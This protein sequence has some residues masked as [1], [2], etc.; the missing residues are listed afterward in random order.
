MFQKLLFTEDT[1]LEQ[2]EF[3]FILRGFTLPSPLRCEGCIYKFK[4]PGKSPLQKEVFLHYSREK[5]CFWCWIEKSECEKFLM[6]RNVDYLLS[7]N[8]VSNATTQ[9]D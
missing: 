2:V 6:S 7:T 3:D 1:T 5:Q 9:T 8:L 4:S